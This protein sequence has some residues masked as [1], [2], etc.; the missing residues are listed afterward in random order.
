MVPVGPLADQVGIGDQ[1]PGRAF[2]GL[3]NADRFARLDQ[4]SLIVFESAQGCNDRIEA[5]P[6]P[7]GAPDTAID[8]QLVRIFGDRRI[9]VVVQHAQRRFLHPALA[10]FFRPGRRVQ[11]YIA[12]TGK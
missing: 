10:T 12:K 11:L 4:Q 8:N 1:D 6:V 5:F 3:E 7:R 9:E 2:A